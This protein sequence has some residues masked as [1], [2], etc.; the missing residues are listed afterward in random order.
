ML[1]SI[2][3]NGVRRVRIGVY[4]LVRI[5]AVLF[6]LLCMIPELR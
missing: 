3:M 2:K 6:K 5:D 1:I 4:G